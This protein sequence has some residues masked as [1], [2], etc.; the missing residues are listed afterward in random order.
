MTL[1]AGDNAIV[2]ERKIRGYL[3]SSTHPAGRHKAAWLMAFGFGPAQWSRLVE[4]LRRHAVAHEVVAVER[5]PF[6]TRYVLEG[7]LV[8]PDRRNP[9]ARSVWFVEDG[10]DRPRFV[11]LY[12]VRRGET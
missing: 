11:T 8:T 4:A 6:G 2:A 3:L 9:L 12:P 5:T 7:P 10:T 1:P